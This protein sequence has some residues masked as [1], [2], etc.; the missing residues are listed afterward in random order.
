MICRQV[1]AGIVTIDWFSAGQSTPLLPNR[2]C[3]PALPGITMPLS[4]IVSH[5]F[6]PPTSA[7][8]VTVSDTGV[9]A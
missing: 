4:D 3:V 9:V 5:S 6:A 7:R 8:A 2:N 1:A